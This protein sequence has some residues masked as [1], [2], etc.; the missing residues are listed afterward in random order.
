MLGFLKLA[1]LGF[2]TKEFSKAHAISMS[3]EN[4]C[5]PNHEVR[6]EL[7]YQV[8]KNQSSLQTHI[9]K[10]NTNLDSTHTPKVK[11]HPGD[12][13]SVEFYLNFTLLLGP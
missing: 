5:P 8:L 11:T 3:M 2:E 10:A 6:T 4:V 12:I 1:V 7:M 9:L 13:T